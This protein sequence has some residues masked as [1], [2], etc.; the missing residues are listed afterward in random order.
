MDALRYLLLINREARFLKT[1]SSSLLEAGFPVFA[2]ESISDAQALLSS[3]AVALI[4]CD[5]DLQDGDGYEFLAALKNSPDTKNLPFIFLVSARYVVDSLEEEVSKILKAFDLGAIDFIID[6]MEEDVSRALIKR[7]NKTLPADFHQES[8]AAGALPSSSARPAEETPSGPPERRDSKRIIPGYAVESEI[9]RDGALWIPGRITNINE[10]GLMME[11]ALLGK[12]GMSVYVRVPLPGAQT[13][14]IRCHI[15]H[16]SIIRQPSSAE[17]GLEAD[18]TAEWIEIYTYIAKLMGIVKAAETKKIAGGRQES[19]EAPSAAQT[20]SERKTQYVYVDP[21]LHAADTGQ[22]GK[23]LESKFYRSLIGKQL[24]NYKAVS[25][26]GAGSMAGVFKGWDVLLERHVALKVISYRLSAIPSFREMF[27]REARMVS[28]LTHPHIAQLYHLDQI[29]DVLYLI[30]EFINGGTLADIL[31]DRNHLNLAKCLEYFITTC[32]TLDFV[33]K[34]NIVHRDIKPANIMIDDRGVLKIVDFGIA[35]A[36]DETS[37]TQKPEGFGSPLYASPECILGRPLDL[38][39]DI[40]S[41]GAT[42]YHVFAGVPPFE[43][44]TDDI[45][46]AKHLNEQLVPLKKISPMVSGDLSDIIGKMMA[47]KPQERYQSYRALANDLTE[48]VH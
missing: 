2:A 16:I 32:R 3:Q 18:D 31:K 19:S 5:T 6:S 37:E 4:I 26:I 28:R 13:V 17:V 40:Y 44:E 36:G 23:A 25:F 48:V 43:G 41:L 15:R 20:P 24:G 11:T 14:A 38:C 22:A 35:A 30:M 33:S 9:S 47:K 7:L 10:Q 34:H 1:L 29:D 39:S 8:E 42:F 12:L 27:I 21:E 46:T 45:I